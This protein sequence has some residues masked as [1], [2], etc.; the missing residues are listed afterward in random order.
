MNKMN[1]TKRYRIMA[2]LLSFFIM[3]TCF[4][5]ICIYAAGTPG[6]VSY[7]DGEDQVILYIN[8]ASG[9][10]TTA[11]AKVGQTACEEV[12]IKP[13]SS[14]DIQVKTL[15]I[16]DTSQSIPVV[17]RELF[18]TFLETMIDEKAE[19]DSFAIATYGKTLNLACDYTTDR[20][21]LIKALENLEFK[22]QYTYLYDIVN[23]AVNTINEEKTESEYHRIILFTDGAENSKDGITKEELYLKLQDTPYEIDTIGST[24]KSNQEEL[25][26]LYALSRLTGGKQFPFTKDADVKAMTAELGKISD[27]YQVTV[28]PPSV[29]LDGS[30]RNIAITLNSGETINADIRMPI[31]SEKLSNELKKQEAEEAEEKARKEEEEKK[32]TELEKQKQEKKEKVQMIIVI[33]A[34]VCGLAAVIVL[35]VV[36]VK[37]NSSKKQKKD[38]YADF[39]LPDDIN[40][41]GTQILAAC[42]EPIDFDATQVLVSQMKVHRVRLTDLA[43]T[44]RI[45]E[46]PLNRPV[47]IGRSKEQS[48]IVVDYDKSVSGKHCL[49]EESRGA[50]FLKDLNSSNHTYLNGTMVTD[51][52]KIK[53]GDTI[54]VGK[55]TF[56][57]EI[58]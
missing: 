54:K 15:F 47:V 10:V 38:K 6:L 9:K 35:I 51:A 13:V 24:I 21:E 14:E 34:G 26:E 27:C 32:K 40:L 53:G 52:V 42:E 25:K 20:W 4:R 57:A 55:T 2:F 39:K 1:T 48:D 16:I 50:V 8:N 23:S 58:L 28:T 17:Q 11:S 37:L 45:F 12:T 3:L 41:D 29:F 18:V 30:I 43:D 49:M 7:M 56:K 44:K 19:N 31:I 5:E 46:K 36:A 33:A 22:K